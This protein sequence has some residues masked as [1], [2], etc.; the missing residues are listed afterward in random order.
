MEIVSPESVVR[1]AYRGPEIV[2]VGLITTVTGAGGNKVVDAYGPDGHTATDWNKR[3][4][5]TPEVID[6]AALD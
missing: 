4:S 2:T 1:V 6:A 5:A 3:N